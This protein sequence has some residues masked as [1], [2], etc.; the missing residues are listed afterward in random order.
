MNK[1]ISY[2]LFESHLEKEKNE[3]EDSIND[4][5]ELTIRDDGFK[6]E[7][8]NN[9]SKGVLMLRTKTI[10]DVFLIVT[11]Y[12]EYFNSFKFIDIEDFYA[13]LYNHLKSEGF[14]IV[15]DDFSDH[16]FTEYIIV[17]KKA[18]IF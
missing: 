5:L 15:Y 14:E 9:N 6:I 4:L 16:Y 12:Q 3:L 7:V 18:S 13:H 8:D 2:K 1:L 10:T 11:V 17:I